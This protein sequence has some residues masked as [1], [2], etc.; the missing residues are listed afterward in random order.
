M[1]KETTALLTVDDELAY[2]IKTNSLGE[3]TIS[4]MLDSTANCNYKPVASIQLGGK[5]GIAV[6]EEA[7]KMLR[8]KNQ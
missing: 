7:L 2:E 5:S 6:L 8:E 4:E 1:Y 3:T